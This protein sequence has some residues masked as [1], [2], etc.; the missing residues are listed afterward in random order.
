VA[1]SLSWRSAIIV[2]LIVWSFIYLIPS[3]TEDLPPWWSGILPKE[4]IHLG[5][6]LQGGVHLILEVEVLKAVESNLERSVEDLKQDFRKN[7]I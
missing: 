7:K 3:L 1:K 4:K 2:V 6:D 5:L